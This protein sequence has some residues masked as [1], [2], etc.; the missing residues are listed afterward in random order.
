MN[1]FRLISLCNFS[2]KVVSKILV[3]RMKHLVLRIISPNK[4]VFVWGTLDYQE[5]SSRSRACAYS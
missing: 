1:H 5:Y 3:I 2:Y 4:G